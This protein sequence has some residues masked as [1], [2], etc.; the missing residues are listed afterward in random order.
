MRM[1]APIRQTERHVEAVLAALDVLECFLEWPVLSTRELIQETRLTRNRVARLAGTLAHRG[2]LTVEPDTG[3]F[4]IGPKMFALGRAFERGRLLLPL[5]R[6]IL[7]ELALKTGESASLYVREGFERVVLAREEGTHAIRH[8]IAEGQ[9]MDLHAGAAG[10]VILAFSPADLVETIL[11]RT[12]LPQR[13]PATITDKAGLRRELAAIRARGYAVSDGERAVDA[14]A[15]AAPVF[16]HGGDLAGALALS[17]PVS[18]F[19]PA[20]RRSHAKRLSAAAERLSEALGGKRAAHRS[21]LGPSGSPPTR[22][23][24]HR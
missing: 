21:V 9:R 24:D 16:E 6:P 13:T 12:G 23:Q 5:A 8:S 14:C 2:F 10:K 4:R 3:I 11:S 7:R 18:R 15:L 20:A 22:R 19:S 17:G 1:K